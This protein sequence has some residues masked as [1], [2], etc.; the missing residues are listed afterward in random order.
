[1]QHELMPVDP[2]NPADFGRLKVKVQLLPGVL[3]GS[4]YLA[5]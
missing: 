4:F 5:E 2:G 1:M 3:R